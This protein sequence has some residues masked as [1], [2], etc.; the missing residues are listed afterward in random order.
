MYE[1]DCVPN[2]TLYTKTGGRL[3]EA[4]R[5]H[6]MIP[7]LYYMSKFLNGLGLNIK[8]KTHPGIKCSRITISFLMAF[9]NIVWIEKALFWG[10]Q[11]T[12][13]QTC[14]WQKKLE[15]SLNFLTHWL[16]ASSKIQLKPTMFEKVL[17]F[18]YNF[19][20][21]KALGTSCL[22]L[23]DYNLNSRGMNGGIFKNR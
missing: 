2:K 18:S 9:Y 7:A 23:Q 17:I 22:L 8:F 16:F 12:K 19:C 10:N 5:P 3:D 13:A 4:H 20:L 6:F 1:S 11:K 15:N 14:L 21:N